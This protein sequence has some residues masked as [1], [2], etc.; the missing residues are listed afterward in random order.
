[1][2]LSYH[3]VV[4]ADLSPLTTAAE[5]WQKM[6]ERFGELK[7]AYEKNIQ[8]ALAN[9]NWQGEAFGAHQLRTR[10]TSVEYAA[11]KTEALAVASLLKQAHTE[12]TRLQ[13]AVKDLVSDAQSK[14]YKVDGEGKAT[15]I[16]YDK[17]SAKDQ[18]T[19][20]HDPDYPQLMAQAAQGA[21]AWTDVIAKAVE[22]VNEADEGV[23]RALTRASSAVSL[24][25]GGWGGF[26]AR[27][28]SDLTKAG[29]PMSE[30]A[31]KGHTKSD[32][33]I[34]EGKTKTH[35]WT[36]E[37]K[38][39][40]TGPAAG[41]SASG[42]AYGKQGT[43]KAYVDLA[44]VTAEGLAS[45]GSVTISGIA[46]VSDGARATAS[47]SL[48]SKGITGQ[49]EGSAGIRGL[50]EGRIEYGPVGGYGRGT[51]FLGV[52]AGATA[53]ATK[54][55]LTVGAK[56]FGG[57][58]HGAAGGVEV[59]G[60]SIGGTAESW[61]GAGAEAWWGLKKDEE[62]GVWKIGGKAGASLP[63]GAGLGIEITVDPDKVAETA[64]HAADAVGHAAN[65]VKNT[66]GS[67]F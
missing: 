25:G 3:D 26:N 24:D 29:A 47:Y 30:A 42:P 2:S 41:V 11:A 9:G 19:L 57:V 35:G 48:S 49:V 14:E 16:G 63:V 6:G 64:G 1:M 46:D 45:N 37:G 21:Q 66:I 54:E 17:L 50:A 36:V 56:A 40:A 22:A 10:A 65:S 62:T 67:W 61:K 28:E 31:A 53:K 55:E 60:I 33:W 18:A 27:A 23:Q 32:K 58:K 38:I 7:T 13:K 5:A 4:T 51:E 15:Y 43:L 59:G 20:R 34:A 52:E 8:S 44:H 39:T 12:L